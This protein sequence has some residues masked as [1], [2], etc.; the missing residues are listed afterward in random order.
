MATLKHIASKSPDYGKP[1]EYLMFDHDVNGSPVRDENGNLRM[2]KHFI[3]DGINCSPFSFDMECERLNWQYHKN[4][5]K[6]D[7]KSHH[8]I[9]SFDPKDREEC[10]LTPERAQQLGMEFAARCFP[11]HQVIICTH[12]DGHNGSRNIHVH[13]IMNSL[14]KLD[15][16]KQAFMDRTIDCR[17]GYKHHLTREYLKYLQSEVMKICEREGLH[18]VDLMTAA[19]TK[20]TEKE[21]RARESGQR[22]LDEL[23]EEIIAAQMKPGTT[24]FQTQ[25]QFLRDAILETAGQARSQEEFRELLMEKYGIRLKDRR[26]RF[27]YLHPERTKYITGRALGRDYEKEHLLEMIEKNTIREDR[28][29]T[30]EGMAHNTHDEDAAGKIHVSGRPYDPS[31]D[32]HAD[33]AAILYIHSELRLVVDLQNCIKAQQ[34]EAY[35]RK[36]KLTNLKEMALTVVFIQEN[37]FD[38]YE[39]LVKAKAQCSI[40]TGEQEAGLN[41]VKE[42][43]RQT[44]AMLHFAGQYYSTRSVHAGFLKTRNKKKFRTEHREELDRY[45]DAVRYFKDN[46]D[47]NIPSMKELKE[48]KESLVR[49]MDQHLSELKTAQQ[50][51]KTL[52]TAVSNV[53]SILSMQ[54]TRDRAASKRTGSRGWEL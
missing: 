27:S 19:K 10:G 21:Y 9:L 40:N 24:V 50:M 2:R 35:A 30:T 42:D 13:M 37:G 34:N 45:D 5:G 11:G 25:K 15:V 53:D 20:V 12:D 44:N 43:L 51:Q 23:N 46:N 29:K 22:K 32:Y 7:I 14:R 16:E 6:S 41:A 39:E 26:G 33:P 28:E 54:N 38:S 17:A 36:V 4:Q 49:D 8:Y 52:Q 47:G 3:I 18:Q 31:Y 48:R 1:L